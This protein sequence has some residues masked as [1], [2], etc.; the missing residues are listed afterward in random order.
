MGEEGDSDTRPRP[1]TVQFGPGEFG[2]D[3]FKAMVMK[4][5]EG[6]QAALA[7]VQPGMLM[8]HI[9]GECI[10]FRA[11]THPGEHARLRIERER[12]DHVDEL[13]DDESCCMVMG[14]NYAAQALKRVLH[15]YL[16]E[17]DPESDGSDD[18]IPS[19]LMSSSSL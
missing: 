17:G 11:S 10:R 3:T 6:G 16:E 14:K 15:N 2:M 13:L 19:V 7:G 5:T 8:E 9:K 4:V 1:L 12:S 18:V